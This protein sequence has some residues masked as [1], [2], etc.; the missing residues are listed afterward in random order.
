ME[1]HYSLLGGEVRVRGGGLGEGQG[2]VKGRGSLVCLKLFRFII[3][4]SFS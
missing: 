3:P 4:A 1:D 2:G